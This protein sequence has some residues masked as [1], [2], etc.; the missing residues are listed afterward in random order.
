MSKRR[1]RRS[2]LLKRLKSKYRLVIMNDD[3][4]EEQASFRLSRLNLYV[5]LSTLLIALIIIILS[6]IVF[7][8]LKEYIPGYADVNLRRDMTLLKLKADSVEK[9]ITSRDIY[10]SNLRNVIE[11]KIDT[12]ADAPDNIKPG[13]ENTEI[14]KISLDDS[15]F[16][17]DIENEVDLSLNLSDRSSNKKSIADFS[18]FTPLKGFITEDF[19]KD[20]T[21]YG[22]D[23]VA[24]ENETIQCVLD[25]TVILASWTLETGYIMA[26]QHENELVSFYKH[27]S[28][29]LKKVGTFVKAGDAIAVIGSSGELTTGP[30]LH[31]ELWYNGIP[32]DPK[33]YIVFN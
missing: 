22:V 33:E 14:N 30:H 17:A 15:L 11:G 2:K 23:I 5:L 8:P 13:N 27:N 26:V 31:F 24:P 32:L 16:R 3:T 4:F 19:D 29:L 18:F 21:H 1:K 7:T 6:T 25:G 28:V 10:L 9:I 20:A 12:T